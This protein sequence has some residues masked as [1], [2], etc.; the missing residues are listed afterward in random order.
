MEQKGFQAITSFP[1]VLAC[2]VLFIVLTTM[3]VSFGCNLLQLILLVGPLLF[4][5]VGISVAL[6]Q[7]RR[8]P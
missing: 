6:Y 8:K 5:T 1:L 2:W 3:F 7:K 4:V